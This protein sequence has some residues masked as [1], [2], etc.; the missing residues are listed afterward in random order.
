LILTLPK[1]ALPESDQIPLLLTNISHA[2]QDSGLEFLLFEPKLKR[3]KKR[4]KKKKKKKEEEKPF[5][6]EISIKME[7]VGNYHNIALFFDKVARL[8]R[9]VNIKDIKIVPKK[10]SKDTVIENELLVSCQAITYKFIEVSSEKTDKKK[11]KK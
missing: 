4:K 6:A 9:I 2:G 8:D 7:V 1:K 11:K 5:Y 10:E 3:K